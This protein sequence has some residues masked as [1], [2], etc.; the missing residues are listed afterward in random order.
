VVESVGALT[1][2]GITLPIGF[3]GGLHDRDVG[4]VRFGWR[5]YDPE[6]GRF[7]AL[8]PMGYSGGDSD[9][10]GYCLDDP[11]NLVDPMGLEAEA[12]DQSNAPEAD[13]AEEEPEYYW[14]IIPSTNACDM[15][16][17]MANVRFYEEPKRPHPNCK[18]FIKKHRVMPQYDTRKDEE[19]VDWI[20][21]GSFLV[22][23]RGGAW[24]AVS[25]PQR[26]GAA[27]SGMY[28]ISVRALPV[29][30]EN[31]R[32]SSYCD[33]SGNCWFAR[34][35]PDEDNG[36]TGLGIHPDGNVPGTEGCIGIKGKDTSDLYELLA[37][38]AGQRLRIQ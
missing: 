32:Q 5:D 2:A 17:A 31:K 19:K 27:P 10:Y 35:A 7:T 12:S 24:K 25:G 21:D 28:T 18:C 37:N 34:L 15:C 33:P 16:Q 26:N 22:S 9:L 11:V 38:G 36:R 3:A 8:D 30:K 6:T 20:F 14:T 29:G 23:T 4:W 13:G 1:D